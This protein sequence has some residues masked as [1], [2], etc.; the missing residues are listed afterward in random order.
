MKEVEIRAQR[1]G[2]MTAK[3]LEHYLRKHMAPIA[4][5]PAAFPTCWIIS[6]LREHFCKRTPAKSCMLK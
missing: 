6:I 3:E 2:K 5:G 4:I 1:I